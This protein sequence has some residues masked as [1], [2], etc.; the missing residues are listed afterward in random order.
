MQNQ[1]TIFEAIALCGDLTLAANRQEIRLIR[2][3]PRGTKIHTINLLDQ[4]VVGKPYYFIQPND[5]LYAEPYPNAP[6][7]LHY[8]GAN[9]KHNCEHIKHVRSPYFI[10]HL[11]ESLTH[12]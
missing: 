5:V 2:Q 9:V 12:V 6:G 3:H 7:V 8:W 1:V 10:Y 11:F 4:S